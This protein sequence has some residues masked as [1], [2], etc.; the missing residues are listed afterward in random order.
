MNKLFFLSFLYCNAYGFENLTNKFIQVDEHGNKTN[1]KLKRIN[2]LRKCLRLTNCMYVAFEF[3]DCSFFSSFES[4]KFFSPNEID[5][6]RKVESKRPNLVYYWVVQNAKIK[7]IMN[8]NDLYTPSNMF[9]TSDR[10]GKSN[11]SFHLDNGYVILPPIDK[12]DIAFTI[13]AWVKLH[14]YKDNQ[15]LLDFGNGERSDN[16]I[17]SLSGLQTS[18]YFYIYHGSTKYSINSNLILPLF[19]WHHLGFVV[20]GGSSYIYLNGSL[21]LHKNHN[22]SN[23]IRKINR[24]KSYIGK[25]NWASNPN[26]D[27]E[28]DDI[29]I[30]NGVLTQYEIKDEYLSNFL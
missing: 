1:A 22:V 25:S 20:T 12:L 30:Y 6:Y 11:S 26:V 24:T 2:C 15:R 10:F 9:Y 13:L 7:E 16:I 28:F 4:F 21:L 19:N 29:K 18:L 27:S 5:L 17:I 8:K 14:S 23:I 3:R